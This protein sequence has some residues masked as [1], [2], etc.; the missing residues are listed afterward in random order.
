M[1]ATQNMTFSNFL[2]L[3]PLFKKCA[4]EHIIKK[5]KKKIALI[6]L[7]PECQQELFSFL[8]VHHSHVFTKKSQLEI[9]QKFFLKN[10]YSTL[11]D[12][13]SIKHLQFIFQPELLGNEEFLNH[14]EYFS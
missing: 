6:H 8:F 4:I 13:I 12:P 5:I 10:P 14:F 2:Q 7:S 11:N 1:Q 9:N 3:D